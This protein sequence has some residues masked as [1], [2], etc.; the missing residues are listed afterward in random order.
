MIYLDVDDPSYYNALESVFIQIEGKLVPFFIQNIK[1][2]PK[3][4]EAVVRFQDVDTPE[5]AQRLIGSDLYLPIEFISPLK[6]EA[7]Y[8]HEI[9]GYEVIDKQKGALGKITSVLEFP[10]NPVFQIQSGKKEVLIPANDDF[11]EKLDRKNK[12]IYLNAPEGL[13]DLYLNE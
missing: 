10:G 11:I 5:K 9:V 12:K 1:F 6:G 2:R 7:F 3:R 4:A 8:F 13:I